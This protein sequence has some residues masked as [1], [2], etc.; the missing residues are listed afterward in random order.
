MTGAIMRGYLGFTPGNMREQ[1]AAAVEAA[2]VAVAL[3][4]APGTGTAMTA[5]PTTLQAGQ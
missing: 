1:A 2:V 4:G 5:A 3:S